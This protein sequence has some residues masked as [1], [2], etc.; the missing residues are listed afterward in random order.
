[1]VPAPDLPAFL[2]ARVIEDLTAD[3]PARAQGRIQA[4]ARARMRILQVHR[5][6]DH[7]ADRHCEGCG[8]TLMRYHVT[9]D[10]DECP[11]LR[12][13]ASVYDMHPDYDDAWRP[14]TP[15][16]G[17]GSTEP[18]MPFPPHTDTGDPH[19]H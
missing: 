4:D 6:V 19:C 11:V 2:R 7:A 18:N 15:R 10:V 1:M 12:A 13:L 8:Y 17:S 16:R 14:D 5:R 9:P 3:W